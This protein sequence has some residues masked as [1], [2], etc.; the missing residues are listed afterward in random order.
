MA[1]AQGRPSR[2]RLRSG[3]KAQTLRL[4]PHPQQTLR[5]QTR[6]YQQRKGGLKAK[7]RRQETPTRGPDPQNRTKYY[8]PED[9][10][11]CQGPE[12][13]SEHPGARQEQELKAAQERADAGPQQGRP[14]A[15]Y[16]AP[17]VLIRKLDVHVVFQADLGDHRPLP[18]DDL[19]V[20]FRV[21][22]D[23]QL[24]AP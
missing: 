21:H 2:W 15:P 22:S 24:K 18:P 19:G 3:E 10:P 1:R 20:V 4:A 7:R 16:L 12:H 11:Q 17:V 14:L 23:T 8:N 9:M 5:R 6:K 13:N